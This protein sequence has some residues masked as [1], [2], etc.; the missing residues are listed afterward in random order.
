MKNDNKLPFLFSGTEQPVYVLKK[1][2]PVMDMAFDVIKSLMLVISF[3]FIGDGC[4]FGNM[5]HDET[6]KIPLYFKCQLVAAENFF[7]F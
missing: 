3:Y 6:H 4:E 5:G 1:I 2:L 7:F